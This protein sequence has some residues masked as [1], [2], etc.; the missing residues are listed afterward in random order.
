[1]LSELSKGKE[2]EKKK[3]LC[4]AHGI[5]EMQ[6]QGLEKQFGQYKNSGNIIFQEILL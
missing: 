3:G 6:I 4:V 5:G 1:M 2:K